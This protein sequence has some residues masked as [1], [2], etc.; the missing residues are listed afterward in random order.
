MNYQINIFQAFDAAAC[1]DKQL[2]TF[3]TVATNTKNAEEVFESVKDIIF[4]ETMKVINM[5]I[6]GWNETGVDIIF[7]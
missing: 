7:L 3:V 2:Y 1:K 6:E 4:R 5:D